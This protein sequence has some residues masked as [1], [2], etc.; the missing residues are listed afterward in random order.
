[1]SNNVC[2]QDSMITQLKIL[3][4]RVNLY[5]SKLWQVS[6]AYL[7]FTILAYSRLFNP[8]PSESIKYLTIAIFIAGLTA[9]VVIRIYDQRIESL[10]VHVS[11]LEEDLNLK[12]TM[13]SQKVYP[14]YGLV[15]ATIII[16]ILL[17]T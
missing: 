13:E 6:F 9:L 12:R 2:Q 5:A 15:V 8:I 16:S 17:G 3:N 10:I 11:S 7:G 4:D 1:M 14:H